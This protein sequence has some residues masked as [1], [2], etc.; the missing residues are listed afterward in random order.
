MLSLQPRSADYI[1]KH[2]ARHEP[3]NNKDLTNSRNSVITRDTHPRRIIF[4]EWP[5]KF[6]NAT[7]QT[8]R[9]SFFA[10]AGAASRLYGG[11]ERCQ[12]SCAF[13]CRLAGIR[14]W[15]ACASK[16]PISTSKFAYSIYLRRSYSDIPLMPSYACAYSYFGSTTLPRGRADIYLFIRS[17]SDTEETKWGNKPTPPVGRD[18]ETFD[19]YSAL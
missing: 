11:R 5:G 4:W 18:F 15:C 2:Y 17:M 1:A 16:Y 14:V 19:R 6:G 12:I 8:Y 9:I 7:S 13:S 10:T 3:I